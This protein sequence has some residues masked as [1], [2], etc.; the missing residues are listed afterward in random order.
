MAALNG[1]PQRKGRF[2]VW[3]L[4][5]IAVAMSGC[6][7]TRNRSAST[8][9]P[10]WYQTHAGR[11]V[12][13]TQQPIE[14]RSEPVKQLQEL[15]KQVRGTL[16]L[17]IPR[18]ADPIEVVILQD[19]DHFAQFM[20]EHYESLPARR[21]FFLARG[22][23]R[24]IFAYQSDRLVEDLRHEATHALLHTAVGDRLPLWLDEGLA[25]VFE[26]PGQQPQ[27][28]HI[29]RLRVE[30]ARGW[31]GDLARLERI[32]DVREMSA[33]DYAQ[34][35]VWAEDLVAP[36]RLPVLRAYLADLKRAE[37]QGEPETTSGLMARLAERGEL[38]PERVA[39]R[40]E[41]HLSGERALATAIRDARPMPET[42]R[43]QSGPNMPG[44]PPLASR[45]VIVPRGDSAPSGPFQAM[46]RAIGR[47]FS[48]VTGGGAGSGRP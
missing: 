36:E 19:A 6:A 10:A 16:D 30:Q 12:F 32:E 33:L 29:E 34:A 24:Q 22:G 45:R 3:C 23:Q 48:A 27:T 20:R 43:L 44:T 17:R 38:D 8:A 37:E 28:E 4:L 18:D 14:K 13:R 42:I 41:R 31:H 1:L 21:A 39:Q 25:E 11:F 5:T 2:S 26:S 40:M 9:Y 7:T 35:W 46:G 47:L 15:E